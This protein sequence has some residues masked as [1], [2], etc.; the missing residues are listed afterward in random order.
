MFRSSVVALVV[1]CLVCTLA[2]A[3]P[4]PSDTVDVS[5]QY[6]EAGGTPSVYL[7]AVHHYGP[8]AGMLAGAITN[9]VGSLASQLAPLSWVSCSGELS[10]TTTFTPSPYTVDL[11][12]DAV[13]DATAAMVRQLWGQHYE[14]A[15]NATTP[16]YHG[17]SY[18]GYWPGQ[19][20]AT[21]ENI[22]ALS[23][24]LALWEIMHDFDG[25]L[26]SLDLGAGHFRMSA[27][28]D[29]DPQTFANVQTWL[30]GLVLPAQYQGPLPVLVYLTSPTQQNL[31]GE[32][33][34]E[35]ATLLL[36]TLGGLVAMR[37][38]T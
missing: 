13:G 34:P 10:Q 15:W 9:P 24:S 25:T 17:G 12:A 4:P 1:G 33:I 23:L 18:T 28:S 26:A 31:V 14:Y 2:A 29:S 8:P 6:V 3:P 11:L 5:Y 38:R 20:A 32:I 27:S 21:A 30:G 22:N 37:R 7:D 35:P 36:M 19:P 16:I